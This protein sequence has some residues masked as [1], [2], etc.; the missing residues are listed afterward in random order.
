MSSQSSIGAVTAPATEAAGV[1]VGATLTRLS[2]GGGSSSSGVGVG[3][4]TAVGVR[5]AVACLG[6]TLMM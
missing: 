1:A 5:T 2:G 3:V 6:G 4:G